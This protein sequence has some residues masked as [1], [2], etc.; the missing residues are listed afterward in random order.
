MRINYDSIIHWFLAYCLH[1]ACGPILGV[2]LLP[3]GGVGIPCSM[4]HYADRWLVL[5]G[6]L[7]MSTACASWLPRAGTRRGEGGAVQLLRV[8]SGRVWRKREM[9]N[10]AAAGL[11]E[12]VQPFTT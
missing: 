12:R 9:V 2:Q 1:W 7:R 4:G 3:W 8:A 6:A 11:A 10:F 5:H